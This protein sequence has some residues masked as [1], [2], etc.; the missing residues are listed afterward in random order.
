MN[1]LALF[2]NETFIEIKDRG[3]TLSKPSIPIH[4]KN[5]L[6]L[7][8]GQ[9]VPLFIYCTSLYIDHMLLQPSLNEVFLHEEFFPL[10][11][12]KIQE[13]IG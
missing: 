8:I 2:K 4:R 9:A 11:L 3:K 13:T 5:S 6:L 1:Y 10:F 7:N 12:E